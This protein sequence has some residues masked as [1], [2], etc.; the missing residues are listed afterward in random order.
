MIL[1]II[2]SNEKK[3]E[4]FLENIYKT[5][6]IMKIGS[7]FIK[8]KKNLFCFFIIYIKKLILSKFCCY[9]VYNVQK[10]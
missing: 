5:I 2:V 10:N 7:F 4:Y 6:T 1:F 3:I 8:L 9:F